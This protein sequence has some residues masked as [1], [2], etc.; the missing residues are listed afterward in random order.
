MPRWL[1]S[2]VALPVYFFVLAVLP[3]P[4]CPPL[5]SFSSSRSRNLGPC[6]VLSPPRPVSFSSC[7]TPASFALSSVIFLGRLSAVASPPSLSS[8][9]SS[10][11]LT[12]VPSPPPPH[13]R[14]L[15]S[16]TS[17]P[18]PPLQHLPCHLTPSPPSPSRL[19]PLHLSSLGTFSSRSFVCYLLGPPDPP[20]WSRSLVLFFLGNCS[21]SRDPRHAVSLSR[22]LLP[23]RLLSLRRGLLSPTPS[24]GSRCSRLLG[25]IALLDSSST[26]TLPVSPTQLSLCPISL[27]IPPALSLCVGKVACGDSVASDLCP[28]LLTYHHGRATLTRRNR[29]SA[30]AR[31]CVAGADERCFT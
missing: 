30:G 7:S 6:L 9:T 20:R 31:H 29:P 13:L 5:P 1:F 21:V 18:T 2:T 24:S 16:D 27:S 25:P 11:P 4:S 17:P 3:Q 12:P 23:W 14:H 22:S 19:P 28:S 15:N 26:L 10:R 8:A